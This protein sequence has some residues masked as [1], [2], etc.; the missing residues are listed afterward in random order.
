MNE[1]NWDECISENSALSV[2]R[3]I[4][5]SE[6]LSKISAGR[7]KF[8]EKQEINPESAS[9]IFEGFYTSAIEILHA[10]IINYGY[11]VSNHICLGYYLRDKLKR[12]DLFNIFDDLRY[13]RNSIVY[14]GKEMEFEIAKK[15]IVDSKNLIKELNIILKGKLNQ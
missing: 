1:A 9:Y 2:S 8:L 13:K 14:Y 10:L 3:D 11:K 5:K 7:I 6:S 4:K 15:S 12:N